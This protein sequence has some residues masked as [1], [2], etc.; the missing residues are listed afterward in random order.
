MAE[1]LRATK[2]H[3][4]NVAD[5]EAT[6]PKYAYINLG[7]TD[8]SKSLNPKTDTVNYIGEIIER[9]SV[10]GY[11]PEW[12]YT[13]RIWTGDPVCLFIKKRTDDE[14]YGDTMYTDYIE[15][16]EDPTIVGGE[17]PAR[18]RKVNLI[19]DSSNGGGG[20]SPLEY[21]G[22]FKAAGE[23]EKGTFT[24]PIADETGGTFTPTT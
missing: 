24:P 7:I 21:S 19:P 8:F 16:D 13:A 6:T 3:Y 9:E 11:A 18:R 2:K 10:N 23:W 12:S 22:K 1:A 20:A 15:Y 5:K 17:Y 4:L 14:S